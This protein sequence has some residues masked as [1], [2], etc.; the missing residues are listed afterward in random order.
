MEEWNSGIENTIEDNDTSVK[1]NVYC[2]KFLI[3]NIQE[4]CD[5]MKRENF[6]IIGIEEGEYSQYKGPVKE[7][8]TKT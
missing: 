7:F 2:K 5:I 3:L 4:V 6:W 1:E 8:S